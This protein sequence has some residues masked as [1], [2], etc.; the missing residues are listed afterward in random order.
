MGHHPDGIAVNLL[1]E[2]RLRYYSAEKC[3]LAGYHE[4]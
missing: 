4:G 1:I 3:M 2:T